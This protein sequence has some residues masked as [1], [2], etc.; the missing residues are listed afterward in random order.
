MTTQNASQ[1][2]ADY[3]G[4]LR[5]ASWP[6]EPERANELAEGIEEH[7]REAM[8]ATGDGVEDVNAILARLGSPEQ[9]VREAATDS[10]LVPTPYP[11]VV[12]QPSL[13]HEL[14]TVLLLTVGSFLLPF[15][16]W[17]AGAVLLVTGKRWLW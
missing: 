10:G 8:A 6:L 17:I 12:H 16:A 14:W 7:I 5:A 13:T 2:V 9:I 4:R 11:V 3:L 1:L 15:I